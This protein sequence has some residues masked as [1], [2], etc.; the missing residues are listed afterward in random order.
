MI[1]TYQVKDEQNIIDLWNRTAVIIG[2]KEMNPA[3]FAEIFTSNPY[4]SK[5]LAF[6]LLEEGRIV[7]FACGCM[8]EELPLGKTSGYLTCI[9]LEEQY[10]TSENYRLLI[11]EIENKFCQAG[12]QQSEVLFFNPMMLPWYIKGTDHHEHNNAPG[13][14]KNSRLYQELLENGYVLRATEEAMYLNLDEYEIPD[15][16]SEKEAKAASEGYEVA[17]YN[18]ERHHGE[19]E[20]LKQLENPL[21]EKE[22]GHCT[23]VGIPVLVAAKDGQ[24]VGFAGPMIRQKS[25]R[26][27]FTGIGVVKE[28]EGH[29]LGT[30]LFYKLCQE[31]KAVGATYMSLYTG[32]DNPA[33]KIYHQVGFETVQE[34]AVMRK[35][36]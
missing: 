19:E 35:M 29:G 11:T 9:I 2:Y 6:E 27:Y 24:V 13:V 20:M 23:K 5:S 7:G 25:G 8:G 34:F 33:A 28:Q 21:W 32:A 17:I 14:F 12:K 31:E 30:I 4:F 26:G 10:E 1:E 22:I 18:K 36:L 3:S 16:I 15:K